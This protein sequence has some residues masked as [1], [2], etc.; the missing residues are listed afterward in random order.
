MRTILSFLLLF[1][2][3]SITFEANAQ[4]DELAYSEEFTYGINFN[5]NAGLI[6]GFDFKWAKAKGSKQYHCFGFGFV[7]VKN[8]KEYRFPNDATGNTFLAYKTNYL[9]VLR[10]F[11][12]REFV[13]FRK[14]AEEGVH[15]NAIFSGG[16]SIGMLKPYYVLYLENTAN[17]NTALSIP[18]SEELNL[19]QIYGVGN[20]TDGLNETKISLGLHTKASLAFEFGQI[21]NSVVGLET[22]FVLEKF[23]KEQ[24]IMAFTANKSFYT[25]AFITLYYGRKY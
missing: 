10:P 9:F 1:F 6:G 19:N 7:N 23:S 18:Y 14:A 15:I 11:Y 5:T 25:S 20:F 17:P 24:K 8:P 21:K 16:P 4:S 12:G 13:L 3:A 2:I 22:G